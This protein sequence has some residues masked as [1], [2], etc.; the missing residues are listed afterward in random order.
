[1][2]T[3]PSTEVTFSV[4]VVDDNADHAASL[5]ELLTVFGYATRMALGGQE[6][7]ES[8]AELPPDVVLLDLM[9]PGMDGHE[10]ARRLKA[11][12][13]TRRPF[14]VAL[15]AFGSEE[16]RARSAAAG[17]DLHLVKPA[18]PAVLFGLMERL[19]AFLAPPGCDTA[20]HPA[21]R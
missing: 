21:A 13:P 7:L 5:S 10:L 19:R 3:P 6:A 16:D 11:Q 1:M 17:I 14:L 2:T 12:S 18:E 15:S 20:E 9:M 8:A 4:L